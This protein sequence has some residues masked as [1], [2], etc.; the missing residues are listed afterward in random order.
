[1]F[2]L[3]PPLCS[4]LLFLFLL[5]SDRQPTQDGPGPYC[6]FQCRDAVEQP[7]VDDLDDEVIYHRAFDA[8]HAQWS[9][10]GTAGIL[11][12]A[13][14][15]P[16]LSPPLPPR[17]RSPDKSPSERSR[18]P[19]LLRSYRRSAPPALGVTL[20]TTIPHSPAY[21]IATPR[22]QSTFRSSL[23]LESLGKQSL[24]SA[25]T[26]SS[27]TTPVSTLPLGVPWTKPSFF[28]TLATHVRSWVAPSPLVASSP[29]ITCDHPHLSPTAGKQH[30]TQQP[31]FTLFTQ[32]LLDGSDT[33]WRLQTTIL[34]AEPRSEGRKPACT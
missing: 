29:V 5:P 17:P 27:L 9:G 34:V 30:G 33:A 24:L 12:W 31:K 2:G 18:L 21:P 19:K 4:S 26:D 3:R 8:P 13:A 28:G 6:S 32:R 10:N 22:Q 7:L 23:S 20:P 1:M 11:A 15:I 25:L 14:E 16:S